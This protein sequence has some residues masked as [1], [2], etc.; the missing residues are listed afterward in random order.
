MEPYREKI[1]LTYKF[2]LKTREELLTRTINVGMLGELSEVN[3]VFAVGDT[4]NFD[5]EQFKGTPDTNLNMLIDFYDELENLMNSLANINEIT[6]EELE[7]FEEDDD[8]EDI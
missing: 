6:E 5:I 2:L 4:Y 7:D 8:K 1:L 3:K